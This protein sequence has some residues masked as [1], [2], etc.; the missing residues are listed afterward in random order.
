MKDF[1]LQTLSRDA[2]APFG[3]L[4][5]HDFPIPTGRDF[6]V[7]VSAAATGW[8]VGIL[9]LKKGVAPYLERHLYSKE[10]HEPLS[11]T[12]I[13]IV[14][15]PENPDDYQIF[16]LD[17]PVCLNEGVWHQ[18]MALSDEAM[19]KVVENSEVPPETSENRDFPNGVRLCVTL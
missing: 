7:V 4:L 11:G 18:V 2:F 6:A 15:A 9:A 14:A 13:L 3:V 19:I 17:K 12:S 8:A 5:E 10:T 1:L 16:L